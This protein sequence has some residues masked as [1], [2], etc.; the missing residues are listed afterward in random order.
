[1]VMPPAKSVLRDQL[2]ATVLDRVLHHRLPPA[3]RIREDAMAAEL[4]ASRTPLREALFALVHEGLID[5]TPE[6]GFSVKPLSAREVREVYPIVWTLEALALETS[7][8]T[9]SEIVPQ[10]RAINRKLKDAAHRPRSALRQDLAWHAKLV[11]LCPNQRLKELLSTYKQ[12]TYRYE[13]LYM[14]DSKLLLESVEEH[15]GIGEE[16]GRGRVDRAIPSLRK[17]WQRGMEL[18]L[19]QLDWR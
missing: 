16:L 8:G 14:S 12:L 7:L 5:A 15:D 11:S 2:R 6:C 3:S 4:G 1:M 17:N 10:L 18:L 13:F 19:R 9:F